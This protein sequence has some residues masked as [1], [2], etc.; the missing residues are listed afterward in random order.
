MDDRDPDRTRS[1]PA[2][3][4]LALVVLVSTLVTLPEYGITSDEPVIHYGGEWQLWAMSSDHPDRWKFKQPAPAELKAIT[5][6]NTHP[7][8]NGHYVFPGFPA[9]FCAAVARVAR[10]IPGYNVID[11]VHAGIALLHALAVFGLAVY[12]ARLL[13]L[14]RAL[15]IASLYALFPSAVGHSH[16][17]VKDWPMTGFYGLT[18][19]SFAV[20]VV[21]D[22]ARYFLHSGLWLGLGIASKANPIFTLPTLLLWLPIAWLLLYRG[23]RLPSRRAVLAACLLPGIALITLWLAWPYLRAGTMSEQWS[24]F[25]EMV[26]FI[27]GRGESKRATFSSYPFLLLLIM[28]PPIELLGLALAALAPF[29]SSKREAAIVALGWIW[30]AVP[31]VRISLPHSNYYDANRHFL[32][33]IPALALLAGLGLDWGAGR[34]AGWAGDRW[35]AM[36]E[37]RIREASLVCAL[38]LAL[39]PVIQYHPFETTYYNLLVGG[40]GGA[41]RLEISTRHYCQDMEFWCPDSEGDY[42][43]FSYRRAVRDLGELADPGASFYPCGNLIGPLTRWQE[44]RPDIRLTGRDQ[45]DWILVVPRRPFCSENDMRFVREQTESVKE[46]RR[47]GGLVYGLY[48]RKK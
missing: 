28:T 22:R 45:A 25:S 24:K 17:N 39:W 35:A 8:G 47:D 34:L 21:E 11:S 12:L 20:G 43:G 4:G 48:R 40:L 41:Q 36:K 14:R 32:E 30:L 16:Y 15:F 3:A 7:D 27:V 5:H 37:W 38:G 46:E 33:Y 10:L 42:W 13:G 29:R 44:L 23:G 6:F 1:L 2:A 18:L 9:V 26:G 31:L 19:V